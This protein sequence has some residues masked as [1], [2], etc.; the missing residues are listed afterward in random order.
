VELLI[1]KIGLILIPLFVLNLQN[2][3]SETEQFQTSRKGLYKA[4]SI[5]VLSEIQISFD[6]LMNSVKWRR[7]PFLPMSHLQ[8]REKSEENDR[9]FLIKP[10]LKKTFWQDDARVANI[11]EQKFKKGEFFWDMK[12]L[13]VGETI[14]V[15]EREGLP[16][17][18]L[19]IEKDNL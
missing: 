11:N 2:R 3:N 12:I 6:E 5:V 1:R 18:L 17:L 9:E 15:L 7:N 16:C 8:E 19:T 14:V 13:Y 10:V 4:D